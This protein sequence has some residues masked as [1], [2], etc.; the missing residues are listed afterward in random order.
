[1]NAALGE[2]DDGTAAKASA[3]TGDNCNFDI[4]IHDKNASL[5]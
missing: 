2:I 3:S 5:V 1:M 4:L